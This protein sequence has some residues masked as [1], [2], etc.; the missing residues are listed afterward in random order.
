MD[1]KQ[2]VEEILKIGSLNGEC[3][4]IKEKA[5]MLKWIYSGSE[6]TIKSEKAELESCIKSRDL[7]KPCTREYE[8]SLKASISDLERQLSALKLLEVKKRKELKEKIQIT[9]N[10]YYKSFNYLNY[11]DKISKLEKSIA[12]NEKKY[13]ESVQHI[14]NFNQKIRSLENEISTRVDAVLSQ[15]EK[16]EKNIPEIAE[17][18]TCAPTLLP[19]KLLNVLITDASSPLLAGLPIDK[20]VKLLWDRN[21]PLSFGGMEWNVVEIERNRARLILRGT[22]Y[23]AIGF[24]PRKNGGW[25]NSYGREKLNGEFLNKFTDEEKSFIIPNDKTFGDKFTILGKEDIDTYLD[26]YQRNVPSHWWLSYTY[27]DQYSED[28]ERY[29]NYWD[30]FYEGRIRTNSDPINIATSEGHYSNSHAIGYRPL[31]L[32]RINDDPADAGWKDLWQSTAESSI[33]CH[34]KWTSSNNYVRPY[35]TFSSADVTRMMQ[36]AGGSST[37]K[38]N[39]RDDV[40][41]NGTPSGHGGHYR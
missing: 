27:I 40:N 37:P 30:S 17:A 41:S 26:P 28:K 38:G 12:E 9:R 14:E 8:A 18:I 36:N 32:V 2:C 13:A 34:G 11:C 3:V 1:V 16:S 35:V 21:I 7:Y 29:V 39:W 20:Q 31:V 4:G 19:G 33:I 5:N 22:V 10:E 25:E 23:D 15:I 24:C 6:K